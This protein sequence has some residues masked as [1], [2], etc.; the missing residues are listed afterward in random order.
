MNSPKVS[1]II[2]TYNRTEY[3]KKAIQ[4]ALNQTYKEIEVIVVDDNKNKPEIREW[5]EMLMKEYPQVLYVQNDKNLGGGRNRNRG[6]EA[7]TG[8]LIA[9]LD[10]DDY[11]EPDKIQMQTECYQSHADDNVGL[12]YCYA[13]AVS[14]S[15]KTIGTYENNDEG[16]PIYEHMLKC[17]AGTSL[18]FVPKNVLIE[19]GMFEDVPSK[20]DS[21]TLLKILA[22]GY[23]VYRVPQI[24]VNY[25]EDNE[26]KISGT[27]ERN[28][29]GLILYRTWVRKYYEELMNM[30]IDQVEYSFAKQL[31]TYYVLNHKYDKA[32]IEYEIMRQM[33]FFRVQTLF[34][35]LKITFPKTYMRWLKKKKQKEQQKNDLDK[36]N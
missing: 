9:F 16:R 11:F 35:Y 33:R 20:Q 13:R 34:A 22:A 6:I 28:I 8:E 31:V 19:V 5:V 18:W 14:V 3:L 27:G 15:G 2:P 17:L 29:E 30:Q 4:S 1:I 24:L 21:I 25:L 32:N 7:A 26:G 36:T 10:D 23:N 12:I